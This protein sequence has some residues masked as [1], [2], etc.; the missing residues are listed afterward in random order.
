[1][2]ESFLL[3]LSE[4]NCQSSFE[5]L[6]L[7]EV[8]EAKRL[9]MDIVGCALGSWSLGTHQDIIAFIRDLGG[10]EEATIWGEGSKAPAHF[11]ALAIGAITGHIEFDSHCE[12]L[13]AIFAA[14]EV[15]HLSGKAV[16]DAMVSTV[17]IV[18]SFKEL[19][20]KEIMRHGLHWPAQLAAMAATAGVAKVKNLGVYETAGGLSLAGCL[21]PIAPYEAFVKGASVKRLYSGWGNMIGMMAAEWADLGVMG[22]SNLIE[23]KLGLAQAWLHHT[24]S[25]TELENAL[26]TATSQP[27]IGQSYKE[28]P[29]N[30][31]ASAVLNVVQEILEISPELIPDEIE[32]INIE[33]YN[34]ASELSNESN[35]AS[36]ISAKANIPYLVSVMLHFGEVL[37]EHSEQPFIED[38]GLSGLASRVTVSGLPGSDFDHREIK[39]PARVAIKLANGR[40]LKGSVE[41]P[42]WKRSSPSDTQLEAKFRKLLS[43]HYAEDQIE[44]LLTSIWHLEAID[45]FSEIIPSLKLMK[46]ESV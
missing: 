19:F 1:M 34:Y 14:A 4:Y 15:E 42:C 25:T 31:C 37:P 28:F 35:H 32:S 9:L 17:N 20:S 40:T 24:P 45:D 26:D 39:R 10:L 30:T 22:P 38:H 43:G 7:E 27:I 23:G 36:P 41:D 29:T 5:T 33:T 44:K 12:Y 11:S 8:H 2:T 16:I 3:A 46:T 21:S 18:A 13:P 6:Q